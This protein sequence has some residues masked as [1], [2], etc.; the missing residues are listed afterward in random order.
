[1]KHRILCY[2][3][4]TCQ[5]ALATEGPLVPVYDSGSGPWGIYQCATFA[6]MLDPLKVTRFCRWNRPTQGEDDIF[7][8]ISGFSI[9]RV[10]KWTLSGINVELKMNHV[11]LI[12]K[13]PGSYSGYG[14]PTHYRLGGFD[15]PTT[16]V[17]D[18]SYTFSPVSRYAG[19]PAETNH[20][21]GFRLRFE[22][23]P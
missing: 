9:G 1:M 8:S 2:A 22:S 15:C 19:F 5:I 23:L 3:L 20:G 17:L 16:D 11:P 13:V 12:I 18:A 4:F 7:C 10:D 14:P 6:S 21:E